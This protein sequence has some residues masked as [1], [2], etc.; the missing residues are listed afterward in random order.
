VDAKS[1]SHEVMFSSETIFGP[2]LFILIT[3]WW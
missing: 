2:H 3:L 1:R